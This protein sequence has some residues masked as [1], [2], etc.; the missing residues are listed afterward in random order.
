MDNPIR[1]NRIFL[2]TEE[3]QPQPTY[4]YG[5]E[6]G[7][8][9]P[10]RNYN[11]LAF[12]WA[13]MGLL[14]VL[15]ILFAV[16][17]TFFKKENTQFTD[18]FP[19]N[20]ELL[21]PKGDVNKLLERPYLPEGTSNPALS[22]CINLYRERFTR[23]AFDYCT[24]FLNGVSTDSEK[25]A[26]LT[27]L[28]VIHDEAGR[29][30]Q[31]IERFQKAILYD[32][33]NVH[34]YYNLTLAY[35]HS[36]QFT[37]ARATALKAKEIAPDDPRV[38]LLAGNLFNEINDPDAAIEAYKEGL[39]SSP[40]DPQLIYNLALSYYKKGEIPQAEEQFKQV[41]LKSKGGK[42]A[43]LSNSYLGNIAYNRGNYVEAEHYFREAATISPNDA[44]FLY[45]L[46][47]VLK[48]NGK[49]EESVKY[50]EMAK[51]AGATDPELFRAIADS[52]EK[53][54]LGEQSIDALQKSL[55]YNPNDIDTLFQLAETYYNRGDLLAAEETYR[56][57]VSSTPGDSFTETALLNLG[58][59]LDQMERYGEAV[60]ALNRVLDINPKNAKAYYNLGLVYKHSGNGTQAIENFRK[61][62][63]L[64]PT[65]LK[66]KEA[67]GD[68]YLE[69]RFFREAI[70]E[71]STILKQKEDHYKVALK[72]A[73]S[74]M[75]MN[76][77]SNA[78]K[79]LLQ[80]LNQSRNQAEIKQ[81]HKKLAL[82]YNRSKDPDL[83]NR[84]KDEAYRSAHMDPEDYEGRLVLAKI[85]LDSN[86][87]LDR[88]K[89]IDE[90]TAI[91]RSEVKPKTAASAYNYLGVAYYKNGEY[92]KAV[93]SFQ[94]CI[95]LDPTNTE[96]YDN[97]RAASAAL[98]ESVKKEG[99]F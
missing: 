51:Q 93:R 4:Y 6:P 11:K 53:M 20:K 87:V 81:A 40:D 69:N 74:Y 48:K 55:K 34:A 92:K 12:F 78:E 52:F 45:N 64:D 56:R 68:Y 31:A 16:W 13:T 71:Y 29:Y 17:F 36:G 27:I 47:V 63:Y 2:E 42:L 86:S 7:D 66:S 39:A 49:N 60:T 46:A 95:D 97:K 14:V 83:K 43:A 22:K 15:A 99:F 8:F 75:G 84:A 73:E 5:E 25:S 23:E 44:K 77:S 70:E 82:L 94:N 76:D 79:V 61:A 32:P 19:G 35:K 9:R 24:E 62:S 3:E 90:L 85:L 50:L 38:A 98:E 28:G 80:V 89:A 58:V 1:K 21:T 67:L 26:A 59:V 65:D 88:E 37:D 30:P 54:N 91:V 72:L 57:I 10:K 18:G 96:A 41:T 33:K